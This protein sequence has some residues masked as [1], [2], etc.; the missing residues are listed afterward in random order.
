MTLHSAV[1]Y[2]VEGSL[3]FQDSRGESSVGDTERSAGITGERS[4]KDDNE[5]QVGES[6]GVEEDHSRKSGAVSGPGQPAALEG[7]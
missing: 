3:E 2:T 6:K 4:Y 5:T 7:C 1:V